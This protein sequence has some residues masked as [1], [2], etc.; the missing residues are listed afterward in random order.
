MLPF[1]ETVNNNL[2]VRIFSSS[3]NESELKWH[4]DNENRIVICEHE[5]D[6]QLQ[7][8]NELPVKIEK[9]KKYFI[10]EGEYHRLIKGTNDLKV[11]V[12]KLINES[13]DEGYYSFVGHFPDQEDP[14]DFILVYGDSGYDMG[15]VKNRSTDELYLVDYNFIDSLYNTDFY[16]KVSDYDDE[17]II[18]HSYEPS[19]DP[20]LEP[21]GI[22]LFVKHHVE[23]NTF[24]TDPSSFEENTGVI[25]LTN[26]NQMILL[27]KYKEFFIDYM[28]SGNET[29]K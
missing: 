3:L 18:G 5:T 14:H 16:F 26:E 22:E 20:V 9:N 29:K 21:S 25:K 24:T 13:D 11:N 23:N 15:I 27:K 28:D 8:D 2:S 1:K 17:G 6:W 4:W 7:M 19:D 10:P 12:Y